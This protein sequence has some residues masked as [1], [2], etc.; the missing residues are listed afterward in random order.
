MTIQINST[1][2]SITLTPEDGAG[3]LIQTVPRAGYSVQADI[4]ASITTAIDAIPD[5]PTVDNAQ[6]ATAWVNF[7]AQSGAT[8]Y[9]SYNVVSVFDNGVGNWWVTFNSEM[10]HIDYSV[11]GFCKRTNSNS[12][13]SAERNKCLFYGNTVGL[14][15]M[16]TTN[17][18]AATLAACAMNNV[19]V[20]G[21]K[22]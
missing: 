4:D 15:K 14:V 5:A 8:I 11:V 13:T 20:F 17:N 9:D 16:L 1:N 7:R 22:S 2:G 21:G 18:A 10:D 3:N 19:I 12:N 6:L